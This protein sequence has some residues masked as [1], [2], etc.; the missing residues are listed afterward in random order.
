MKL[1]PGVRIHGIKPEMTIV[2]LAAERIWSKYPKKPDPDGP[3]CTITSGIEGGHSRT[4]DHYKGYAL[5][6]RTRYFA[7]EYKKQVRDD[8]K[9]ALGDDFYIIL[10]KSHL[11]A[12]YR[13]TRLI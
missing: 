6:F 4:S 11:H 8:M 1:K 13:P 10:H 2:M 3:E 7:E 5:D 9:E 12:S